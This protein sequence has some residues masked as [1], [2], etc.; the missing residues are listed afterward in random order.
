MPGVWKTVG[1]CASV[2]VGPPLLFFL[3]MLSLMI[4]DR[5]AWTKAQ[6]LPFSQGVAFFFRNFRNYPY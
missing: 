5:V 6:E 2:C 4:K 1:I 3:I